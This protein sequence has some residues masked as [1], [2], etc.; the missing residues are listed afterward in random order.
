MLHVYLDKIIKL[1]LLDKVGN[2]LKE[3]IEIQNQFFGNFE[4]FYHDMLDKLIAFN[5]SKDSQ[6]LIAQERHTKNLWLL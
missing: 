5:L 1:N 3:H 4:R 2:V 6:T